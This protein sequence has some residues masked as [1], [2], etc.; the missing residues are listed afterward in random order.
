[1]FGELLQ[2]E[3]VRLGLMEKAEAIAISPTLLF[4]NVFKHKTLEI[5]VMED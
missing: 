1:M 2:G 4:L 3:F 5:Y